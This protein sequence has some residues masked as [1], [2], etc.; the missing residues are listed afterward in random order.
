MIEGLPNAAFPITRNGFTYHPQNEVLLPWFAEARGDPK[1][2]GVHYGFLIAAAGRLKTRGKF[3][4][5]S[6]YSPAIS[7][8]LSFSMPV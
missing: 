7:V 3:K 2:I 6:P 5:G 8:A 4:P 1:Q